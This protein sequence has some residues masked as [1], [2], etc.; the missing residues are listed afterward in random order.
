MKLNSLRV[1]LLFFLIIYIIFIS[2]FT[3]LSYRFFISDFVLLEKKLNNNNI[4]TF[5]RSMDK[6]FKN[7]KNITMDYSS[8]DETYRF[9]EDRNSEYIFENFRKGSNTLKDL[10]I[11]AVIFSNL[12]KQIVFSKYNLIDEIKDKKRF[13]QNLLNNLENKNSISSFFKYEDYI[14]CIVKSPI[15]KSDR[16][17]KINGYLF[18]I[19]K[20]TKKE[21]LSDNNTL[22][23]NIEIKKER[24]TKKNS[25]NLYLNQFENF[26][27]SYKVSDES[28]IN[29]IDVYDYKKEFLF[30]IIAANSDLI[31]SK[32]KSAITTFNVVVSLIFLIIFIVVY[33]NQR[34]II[35]QNKILNKKIIKRTRQLNK[36]YKSLKSKNR[37]LFKLANIDSLTNINNRASFFT[38]SVSLL[39]ESNRSYSTF[40]ILIIDI[41]HF[42][43]INDKYSHAIGDK[44]L[45][46]FAQIVDSLV[47]EDMVFGRIGGEEF[48]VSIYDKDDE[49]VYKLSEQIRQKCAQISIQ[50]NK[51]EIYFT[52]SIGIAFKENGN[53][54]IDDIL[55]KADLLLYEAKKNG[56]NR[57]IRRV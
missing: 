14:F 52:V 57:V 44:V 40:A 54:T 51:E 56:R 21:L 47:S 49:F 26:S 25:S 50:D 8:W 6:T 31:I 27:I 29:Y 33:Q 12:K 36:A 22:F 35:T 28:I 19:K 4:N 15:L 16:S 24:V 55:H 5:L 41:D 11:N 30:T 10:D 3:F 23:N 46:K 9:I 38:K 2:I 1:N 32:G 34:L 39:K 20:I 45:I 42:K 13:E 18:F 37:A 53:Q 7:L 48:C 17:G 43:K